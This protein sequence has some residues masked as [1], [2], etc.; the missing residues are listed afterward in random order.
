M[1]STYETYTESTFLFAYSI[2]KH[3][4]RKIN[5]QPSLSI[6]DHIRYA[7]KAMSSNLNN[8]D[9]D[10]IDA[11][12]RKARRLGITPIEEYLIT[13]IAWSLK[14]RTMTDT[15][16]EITIKL[17]KWTGMKAGGTEV[18]RRKFNYR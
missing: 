18:R 13:I 14:L 15:N 7:I 3:A 1:V 10:Q 8:A 2:K 16:L 6:S 12:L 17:T 9:I 4:D 5:A 11:A